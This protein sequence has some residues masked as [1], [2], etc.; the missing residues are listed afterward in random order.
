S[1]DEDERPSGFPGARLKYTQTIMGGRSGGL[2]MRVQ[3]KQAS[4]SRRFSRVSSTSSQADVQNFVSDNAL[5]QE[6]TSAPVVA[7]LSAKSPPEGN[8]I[9]PSSLQ[10]SVD[11][12]I[13]QPS[14]EDL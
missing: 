1:E 14:A 8:S 4:I 3:G 11:I 7:N 2:G 9:E 13:Q 10:Q 6:S 12:H 5:A